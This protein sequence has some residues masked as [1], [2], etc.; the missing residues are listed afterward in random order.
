MENKENR[1]WHGSVCAGALTSRWPFGKMITS[2]HHIELNSILGR[3]VLPQEEVLS[4]ES[5]KFFPWLGMGIRIHHIRKDY[6]EPL[7]FSPIAFWRRSNII[8]H[9]RSLGYKVA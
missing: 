5:A 1:K 7:M 6:P 2:S 3:F 9:L 8:E 4:I